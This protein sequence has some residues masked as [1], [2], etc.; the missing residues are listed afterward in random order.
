VYRYESKSI[1][2]DIYWRYI[3][4]NFEIIEEAKA[5]IETIKELPIYL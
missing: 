3:R 5:F 2:G 4:G 1:F